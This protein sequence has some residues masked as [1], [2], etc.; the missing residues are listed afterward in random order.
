MNRFNVAHHAIKPIAPGTRLVGP[1]FTVKLPA[2]DNLFLMEVNASL[3]QPGDV[4]V[5][6]VG[7]HD[8]PGNAVMGD[9]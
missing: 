6:D 9:A 3:T 1:A 8:C 7:G 2:A 4:L 5:V